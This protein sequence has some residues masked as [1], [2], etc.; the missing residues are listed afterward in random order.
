MS[1]ENIKY[2]LVVEQVNS[3]ND[4]QKLEVYLHYHNTMLGLKYNFLVVDKTILN[5][6]NGLG[7]PDIEC[8]GVAIYYIWKDI[9]ILDFQTFTSGENINVID[10]GGDWQKK[11]YA[12][13]YFITTTGIY[14]WYENHKFTF[15]TN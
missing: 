8:L 15:H 9:K 3:L 13:R 4:W 6:Q 11:G 1:E 2:P 5:W 14:N 12:E 10:I 7:E